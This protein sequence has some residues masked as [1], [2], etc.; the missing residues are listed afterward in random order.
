[1]KKLETKNIIT[2]GI[3]VFVLYLCIHYWSTV[4]GLL[5]TVFE[6]LMPLL[7]GG[8]IAYLLNI[9]MSFYERHF[10]PNTKKTIIKNAGVRFACSYLSS[11]C[12]EYPGLLSV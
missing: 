8:I 9:L 6:A 2:L 7:I 5:G 10:F 4:S 12:L 11:V 3:T 1:M